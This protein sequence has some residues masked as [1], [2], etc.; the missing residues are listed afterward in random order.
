MN[1]VLVVAALVVCEKGS[2]ILN[3]YP[4]PKKA[5]YFIFGIKMKIGHRQIVPAFEAN[6]FFL[7]YKPVSTGNA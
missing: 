5:G 7:R 4:S 1:E 3:L 6:K 2:G